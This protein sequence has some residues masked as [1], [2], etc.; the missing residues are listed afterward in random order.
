[1]SPEE[2]RRETRWV[3]EAQAGDLA[4]FD[5]LLASVQA[6]LFAYLLQI[7]RRRELAEDVLQDVFL[8]IYRKL[9]WLEQPEYFRA[10]AWRIAAREAVRRAHQEKRFAGGE[11][12][13]RLAA[14]PR[15]AELDRDKL[16]G[17]VSP[18]SRAV[19]ALHFLDGLPLEEA[20]RVLGLKTGTA[21]SRL[22]YGLAALRKLLTPAPSKR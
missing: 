17:A 14:P 21:K 11:G 3:L 9:E 7:L 16:L 10:W 4:S 13:E 15:A 1:M 12:L 19:L 18:A 22:A 2:R 6:P 20:A 8:K 5:A